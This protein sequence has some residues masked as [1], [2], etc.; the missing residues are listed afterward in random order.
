MSSLNNCSPVLQKSEID[1]DYV[2]YKIMNADGTLSIP[3]NIPQMT[4]RSKSINNAKTIIENGNNSNIPINGQLQ[5]SFSV[6]TG[7][8]ANLGL[9]LGLSTDILSPSVEMQQKD[10]FLIL[11]FG[12]LFGVIYL[13]K[14]FY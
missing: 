12:L 3:T 5:E 9:D 2:G 14:K 10:G 11:S 1:P 6:G 13:W 4:L 7:M 8:E